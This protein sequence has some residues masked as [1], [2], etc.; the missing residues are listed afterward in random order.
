MRKVLT[1]LCLFV[2]IMSLSAASISPKVPMN[3][4]E[5]VAVNAQIVVQ[6]SSSLVQGSD[7]CFLNGEYLPVTSIASNMAIFKP[8]IMDYA[9]DYEFVVR[10]GAFLAKDGSP[11]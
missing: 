8:G 5:N 10:D 7:S 6:A 11:M 3:N 2:S 1:T 9:T 4:Q